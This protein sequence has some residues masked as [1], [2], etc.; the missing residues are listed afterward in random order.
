MAVTLSD[1]CR[2]SVVPPLGFEPTPPPPETGR[3]RDRRRLSASYHGL[4][5]ASCVSGCLPCPVVRSTSHPTWNVLIGR[6]RDPRAR[7]VSVVLEVAQRWQLAGQEGG[8]DPG[9]FPACRTAGRR[10]GSC[11]SGRRRT[12][13]LAGRRVLRGRGRIVPAWWAPVADEGPLG[14]LAVGDQREDDGVAGELSGQAVRGAAPQEC[15][16]HRSDD[17]ARLTRGRRAGMCTPRGTRTGR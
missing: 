14:Q 12:G 8:G 16:G 9:V 7:R 11:P 13:H 2:S 3:S 6:V 15:G 5:F 10:P 4:L 1:T 17:D